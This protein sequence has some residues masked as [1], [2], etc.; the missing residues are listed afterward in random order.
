M[1][2]IAIA[3]ALATT[4]LSSTA[5]AA[6]ISTTSMIAEIGCK[7]RYSEDKAADI[8]ANK[9]RG[10][11]AVAKGEIVKLDKGKVYLKLLSATLSYDIDIEL[12]DPKAT[13][14]MEKGQRIEV[15]FTVDGHGGCFLPFSG[16]DGAIQDANL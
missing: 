10:Q 11:R 13:Y 16:N 9:Y 14:D 6:P 4:V 3:F 12:R 8:F 5:F 1:K 15:E 7:T 2:R